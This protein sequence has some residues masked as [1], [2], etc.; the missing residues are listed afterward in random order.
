MAN[1]KLYEFLIEQ[2]KTK[3]EYM[4]ALVRA[5]E[6][7][8]ESEM[9][10]TNT[11]IFEVVEVAERYKYYKDEQEKEETIRHCSWETKQEWIENKIQEWLNPTINW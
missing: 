4:D 11:E 8:Y 10:D 7:A 2:A 9:V 3:R 6:E 1:E 5:A